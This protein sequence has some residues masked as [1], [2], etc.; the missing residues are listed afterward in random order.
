MARTWLRQVARPGPGAEHT[1]TGVSDEAS[2]RPVAASVTSM[3][4]CAE[5]PG[6]GAAIA[7]AGKVAQ[8]NTNASTQAQLRLGHARAL[9]ARITDIRDAAI[10]RVGDPASPYLYRHACNS[11]KG[12]PSAP[13]PYQFDRNSS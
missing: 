10:G 5:A 13:T 9:A 8:A 6:V 11:A 7:V 4:A 12:C 2:G 1:F 3:I